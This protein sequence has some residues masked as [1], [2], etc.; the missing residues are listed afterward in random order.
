MSLV[1]HKRCKKQAIDERGIYNLSNHV[2]LSLGVDSTDV[3]VC[4]LMLVFCIQA[5][6]ISCGVNDGC[7]MTLEQM[8]G[9]G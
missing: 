6:C 2:L 1:C 7:R 5:E 9:C 3:H 8:S 4:Q